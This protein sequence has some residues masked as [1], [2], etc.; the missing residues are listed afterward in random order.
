[1]RQIACFIRLVHRVFRLMCAIMGEGSNTFRGKS[2]EKY[3]TSA[4]RLLAKFD[5]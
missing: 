5:R 2:H 3:C 4:V 1:M